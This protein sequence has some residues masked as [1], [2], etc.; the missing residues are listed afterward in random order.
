MSNLAFI[1]TIAGFLALGFGFFMVLS[2]KG[3][4]IHRRMGHFYFIS[5]IG[6]T[7]TAYP[8]ITADGFSIFYILSTN[9]LVL[10][11]MGY[12]AVLL[13]RKLKSW[14]YWHYHGMYWSFAGLMGATAN[15][16]VVHVQPIYEWFVS[17]GMVESIVLLQT[18][19]LAIALGLILRNQNPTLRRM[20][21]IA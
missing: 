11:L 2:R 16:I 19:I 10:T 1:H 13:R 3:T 17:M 7:T 21:F 9:A 8:I 18:A 20:G 15:E 4:Q 6:L 5:M 12:G 14:Y